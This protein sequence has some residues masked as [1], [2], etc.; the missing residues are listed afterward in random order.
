MPSFRRCANATATAGTVGRV[1]TVE[2]ECE[3]MHQEQKPR[4]AKRAFARAANVAHGRRGRLSTRHTG[5]LLL[6]P[7]VDGAT[8]AGHLKTLN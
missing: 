4:A 6:V 3:A 5:V 2:S 1:E 7:M 8:L